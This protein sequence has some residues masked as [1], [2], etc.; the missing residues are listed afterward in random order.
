MG[1]GHQ[2]LPGATTSFFPA[3]SDFLASCAKVHH[4][5]FWLTMCAKATHLMMV[6]Q[7][8]TT[9]LPLLHTPHPMPANDPLCSPLA[10]GL[11][12]TTILFGW[13]FPE[14]EWWS[15]LM[16]ISL[17]EVSTTYLMPKSC[18]NFNAV[19][20]ATEQEK[21]GTFQYCWES[22]KNTFYFNL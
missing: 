10:N 12:Y 15:H 8:V 18:T 21:Q 2:R 4:S 14:K 13:K 11:K 5:G 3:V 9:I 16:L 20:S 1:N 22:R 19:S 6:E 7:E 17:S